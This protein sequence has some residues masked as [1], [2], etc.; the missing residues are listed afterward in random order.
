[1]QVGLRMTC[2]GPQLSS[3]IVR[4]IMEML[5]V[6]FDHESCCWNQWSGVH[7]KPRRIYCLSCLRGLSPWGSRAVLEVCRLAYSKEELLR[8]PTGSSMADTDWLDVSDDG[9]AA[10]NLASPW[11]L[12]LRH[13]LCTNLE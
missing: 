12:P 4:P 7:F 13:T 11:P 3:G 5:A 1:M 8:L 6:G 9:F 10:I 2:Q